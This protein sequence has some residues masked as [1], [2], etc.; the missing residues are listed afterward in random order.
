MRP[1][2]RWFLWSSSAATGLTG[3]VYMWMKYFM[4]PS[5]PW[6]VINHPLQ[7]WVLKAHILVAPLMVFAVGLVTASHIWRHYKLGVRQG[8]ISGLT[9]ALSFAPVVL[10]G[11]LI[12]AVTHQGWLTA[13]AWS[14]IG[15]GVLYLL[16][17][18]FHSTLFGR[19]RLEVGRRRGQPLESRGVLR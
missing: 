14:H 19:A 5:E 6:A 8:R 3:V 9:A 12:Q 15:F 11:Y 16:A 4:E 7:P 2:E 17:L 13:L 10:T 18:V 1:F